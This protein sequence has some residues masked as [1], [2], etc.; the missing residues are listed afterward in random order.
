MSQ[1]Q[2]L[3]GSLR[4]SYKISKRAMADWKASSSKKHSRPKISRLINANLLRFGCSPT[5]SGWQAR[6]LLMLRRFRS[7]SSRLV[8]LFVCVFVSQTPLL[9]AQ[10]RGC[11]EVGAPIALTGDD[12]RLTNATMSWQSEFRITK[13]KSGSKNNNN[14]NNHDN[15][16]QKGAFRSSH[17]S[18]LS[19]RWCW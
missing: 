5:Q 16:S 7:M 8:S 13:G 18:S 17:E 9:M 6:C 19:L 10:A 4:W 1:R 11:K 3:D 15:C 14:N 2:W 12:L